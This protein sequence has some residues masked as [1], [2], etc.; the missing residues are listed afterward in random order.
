MYSLNLKAISC[1]TNWVHI[2]TARFSLR[3]SSPELVTLGC[4]ALEPLESS[5]VLAEVEE[6]AGGGPPLV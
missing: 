6:V 2:K 4:T 5:I 3:N 1:L